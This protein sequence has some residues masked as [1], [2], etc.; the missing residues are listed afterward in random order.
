MNK[1][2]FCK[3]KFIIPFSC[4]LQDDTADRIARELGWTNQKYLPVDIIPPWFSMLI[5]HL[6]VN[7]RPIGCSSEM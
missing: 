6:G 1:K 3:A 7:N 2:N 4:L 5:Y